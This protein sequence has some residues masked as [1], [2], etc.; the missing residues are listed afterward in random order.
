MAHVVGAKGQVVIA[1]A[2]REALGVT[3][4]A[5]TIQRLVGDHVEIYFVPPPHTRSLRGAVE[6]FITRRPTGDP[7][8]TE[9]AWV[10]AVKARQFGRRD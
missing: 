6:P 8:D 9:A 1:R 5:R 10:S 3:P 2:I 4:G 7:D